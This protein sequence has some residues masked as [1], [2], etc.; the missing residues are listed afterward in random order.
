[1]LNQHSEKVSGVGAGALCGYDQQDRP[2][3]LGLSE[4]RAP[5][6]TS[7]AGIYTM[8]LQ[9]YANSTPAATLAIES[10]IIV[11]MVLFEPHQAT[12]G[13]LPSSYADASH[14]LHS[15]KF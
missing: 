10:Q 9:R 5:T 7:V 4:P 3:A 1:M 8:I 2:N 11:S 12:M 13:F 6:V 14:K 15:S